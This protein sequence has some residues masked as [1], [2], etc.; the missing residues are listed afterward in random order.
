MCGTQ[1]ICIYTHTSLCFLS[2]QVMWHDVFVIPTTAFTPPTLQP[3]ITYAQS[4]N[5]HW[6][7]RINFMMHIHVHA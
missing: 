6:S 7:A 2:V 5:Y 3:Y 1:C 4:E